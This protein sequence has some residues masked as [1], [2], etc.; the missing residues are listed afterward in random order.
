MKTNRS[1]SFEA[2]VA[3]LQPLRVAGSGQ[4]CVCGLHHDSRQVRPGDLFFAIPGLHTDGARY[5]DQ[6]L[7]KGAVAVVAALPLELPVPCLQVANVRLALCQAAAWFHDFPSRD[8]KL[9]GV[10][11][12]NGKTT[13]CYLI[14]ALLDAGIGP[15]GLLGTIANHIGDAVLPSHCTTPDP[16]ELFPLLRQMVD[17]ELEM[18]VMEVS[19]HA[20]AQDRVSACRFDTAIFTNLTH[21]HLDFHG[22]LDHYKEAKGRLFRALIDGR[23][24]KI[25]NR[26]DAFGRELIATSAY[27]DRI[28]SY[29]L[30]EGAD[31]WADDLAPEATGT[32]CTFHWG[33]RQLRLRLPLLGRFNVYNALAAST[34]ALDSGMELESIAEVLEGFP[35]V[36]GRL[37]PLVCGQPFRVYIDYAHTPDGLEQVLRTLRPLCGGRLLTLF[38]CTGDRDRSKRPLMGAIAARWSDFVCLTSDDPHNENPASIIREI[39]GGVLAAGRQPGR[40]YLVEPD[41]GAAIAAI[42]E[43]AQPND[44]VLLAGKGHEAVQIVG[45]RPVAFSDLVTSQALLQARYA[46]CCAC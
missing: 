23:S 26:D 30:E 20:L 7:A 42:L 27:P 18:A 5:I 29:A 45:D 11:G 43:L 19:S 6:A 15:T 40:D 44:M 3:E 4:P 31:L 13:T 2:L 37:Q 1:R 35:G 12:T 28:L 22:S 16:L 41:R 17:S 39:E 38:G 36:P 8:L 33:S 9:V 25:I 34:C 46:R 21:D 10:S 32:T 14:K 24:R